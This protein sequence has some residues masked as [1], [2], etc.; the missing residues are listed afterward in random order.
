[1]LI[2]DFWICYEIKYFLENEC[3]ELYENLEMNKKELFPT[4]LDNQASI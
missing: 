4:A 3:F 2:H 1:M